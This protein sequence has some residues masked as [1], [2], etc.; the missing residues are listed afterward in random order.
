M[1][2]S[3]PPR[4]QHV[5]AWGLFGGLLVAA[6]AYHRLSPPPQRAPAAAPEPAATGTVAERKERFF[7][8]LR[9]KVA[10]ENERI[11]AQRERLKAL[12]GRLDSGGSLDGGERRW[13]D[14][15]A[16]RYRVNLP[17]RPGPGDLTPLLRK[18]DTVP[19]ALVLAQA[20]IESN[21]G[22]S[23]FAREGNNLFGLWCFQE[24]CGLVPLRRE[25]GK[26]HEV[27][28]FSTVQAGVRQYLLNLNRHPRY[29]E[30]RQRRATARRDGRSPNATDL[31]AGL[32]GYSQRGQDYVREV[33]AVIRHN[34]LG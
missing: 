22:R 2:F 8:S 6:I 31:A 30:L 23:R 14:E 13:L 32:D 28:N 17:D 11:R 19:T 5:L 10:G 26:S 15:L 16:R 18:V 21:W 33:R 34:D 20:A 7:D 4:W 24:G 1:P 12:H 27:E 3:L 29:E 25:G 9:P